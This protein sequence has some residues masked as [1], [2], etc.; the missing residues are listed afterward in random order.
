M[1]YPYDRI[2]F[3]HGEEWTVGTCYNMNKP[4]ISWFLLIMLEVWVAL[5]FI[6]VYN[7]HNSVNT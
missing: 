7:T 4:W 1:V 3:R 2:L 6:V 5:Y